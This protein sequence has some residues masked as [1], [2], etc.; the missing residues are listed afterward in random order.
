M[1][2]L[3]L[4]DLTDAQQAMLTRLAYANTDSENTN[5]PD[6]RWKIESGNYTAADALKLEKMS[7]QDQID[8]LKGSNDKKAVDQIA[9]LEQQKKVI[10]SLKS[11]KIVDCVNNNDGNGSGFV[12]WVFEDSTQNRGISVR[13]TEE[14][15][16]K[17]LLKKD[18]RDNISTM[19][20]GNSGQSKEAQAFFDKYKNE[21]GHNYL[22]GH[23]K[24]GEIVT[25][26]L[27]N[28]E[29]D[30]AHAFVVNA[31]PIN[32]FYYTNLDVL[33]TSKFESIIVEGDIVSFLGL[34]VYAP[35]SKF[36]NNGGGWWSSHSV[37]SI[38]FDEDQ[39]ISNYT[40]SISNEFKYLIQNTLGDIA[41][42]VL[43]SVQI[44]AVPIVRIV[45]VTIELY[46][47]I[48]N[49]IIIPVADF[50][51]K[52]TRFI[53]DFS[54]E[55]IKLFTGIYSIVKEISKGVFKKGFNKGY[56]AIPTP[57][58]KVDTEH[59]KDL[60]QRLVIVRNRL[61]Q[62]DSDLNYLYLT[63]PLS[64][65]KNLLKANRLLPSK[66]KVNGCIDYLEGTAIAFEKAE[67]NIKA[68]V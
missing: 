10:D 24:G 33:A 52:A 66:R 11:L 50:V 54:K 18:M 21:D 61:N 19:V 28:N 3:Q 35:F 40:T 5:D 1:S 51:E 39:N 68:L 27:L 59:L 15:N 48:V 58:I 57:E 56:V 23:S 53:G 46:N 32:P 12:A 29:D 43:T 22:F 6:M 8:D 49:E 9:Q 47:T 25:K 62:L 60:A 55:A 63:E 34:N 31:Q 65:I 13:G 64:V 17:G 36:V 44:V 37:S 26:L 67:K 38:W 42:V 7:I 20:A 30:V 45:E 4:K 14:M 16:L 2:N 41:S